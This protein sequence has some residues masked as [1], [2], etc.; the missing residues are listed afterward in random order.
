MWKFMLRQGADDPGSADHTAG[1]PLRIG[2]FGEEMDAMEPLLGHFAAL[3]AIDLVFSTSSLANAR[4]KTVGTKPEA[5]VVVI[6]RTD[7]AGMTFL[8]E[9]GRNWPLPVVVINA[10]ETDHK[11]VALASVRCGIQSIVDKPIGAKAFSDLPGKIARMIWPVVRKSRMPDEPARR[12]TASQ[13]REL[14]C[15]VEPPQVPI[16]VIVIGASTGGLRSIGRVMDHLPSQCPPI[17]IVQHIKAGY[18]ERTAARFDGYYPHKFDLAKHGLPTR[19]N[20]VHFAPDRFHLQIEAEQDL[21]HARLCTSD[22]T[23]H[24]VPA[25]NHLF[26]SASRAFGPAAVGVILTGMG[27]DGAEGLL[28]MRQAGARCIG[29]AEASCVVYGMPRAAKEIGAVDVELDAEDIGRYL[30][31]LIRLAPSHRGTNRF[32]SQMPA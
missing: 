7:G 26:R 27:K 1:K 12:D 14:K 30:A 32:Q 25:A 31:E 16:S 8:K 15:P 9:L 13:S 28:D 20:Q 19:W 6:D 22:P 24:F 23:D 5:M 2:F 4:E 17:L 29:E 21:P 10:A 18:L 3:S 11:D